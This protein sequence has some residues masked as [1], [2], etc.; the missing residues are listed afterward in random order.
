MKWVLAVLSFLAAAV[1]TGLPVYGVLGKLRGED[2][3]EGGFDAADLVPSFVIG[4]VVNLVVLA[5]CV[6]AFRSS[7]RRRNG[8][9]VE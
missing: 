4:T 3:F 2:P 6:G 1:V 9:P 7:G 5:V 8:R